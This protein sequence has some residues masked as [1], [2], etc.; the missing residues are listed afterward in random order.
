MRLLFIEKNKE[1]AKDPSK[2]QKT[3]ANVKKKIIKK[4]FNK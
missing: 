4:R 1:L 3:L 2:C